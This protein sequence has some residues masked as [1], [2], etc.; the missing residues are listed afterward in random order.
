M[1]DISKI[2][3]PIKTGSTGSVS[4]EEGSLLREKREQRSITKEE[5]S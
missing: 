3:K 5:R 4:I 1:R 2:P